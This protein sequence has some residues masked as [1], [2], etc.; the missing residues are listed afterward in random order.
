[1]KIENKKNGKVK[2]CLIPVAE[3]FMHEN[4]L[5]MRVQSQCSCHNAVN[6]ERGTLATFKDDADVYERHCSIHF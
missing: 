2:F 3:T 6:L 1:M 5:Y 4:D